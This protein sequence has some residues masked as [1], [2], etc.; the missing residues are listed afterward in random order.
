[1]C[2]HRLQEYKFSTLT[3]SEICALFQFAVIHP[4]TLHYSCN[5]ILI[6]SQRVNRLAHLV[7]FGTNYFQAV[8]CKQFKF[9]FSSSYLYTINSIIF[10]NI[11]KLHVSQSNSP[12]VTTNR[13]KE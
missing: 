7:C 9:P 4:P 6:P 10:T 2:I 12:S 5:I 13:T 8:V 1:M 3:V 11:S